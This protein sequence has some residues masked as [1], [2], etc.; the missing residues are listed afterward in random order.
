MFFDRLEMTPGS[1]EM[2]WSSRVLLGINSDRIA[3]VKIVFEVL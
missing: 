2:I 1:V 3:V